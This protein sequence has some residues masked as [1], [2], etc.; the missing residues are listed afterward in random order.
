MILGLLPLALGAT[1][2]DLANSLSV[3]S[4]DI[5]SANVNGNGQAYDVL[6]N[7]GIL[8]PT[9][10]SDFAI[11]SSG[12][13]GLSP[14]PG[15]DLPPMGRPQGDSVKFTLELAVPTNA[16]SFA[17]DF[18]FLS[19]EYPEYVGSPYNDVFEAN[20]S[21][22]AWSGNAAV[23]SAGNNITVNSALFSVT[24]TTDLQGS[25]FDKGVGGGT[26]WLTAVVPADPGTTL[27]LELFVYDVS[28]G[29]Y[30]SV[31]LLDDFYWSESEIST[32]VVVTDI[33][34]SYLS[35]K[36]G[37]AN[38]GQQT[39]VFGD[40][41]NE[42]C[43]VFFDNV[44]ALSTTYV[45]ETELLAEVPAHAPDLVDVKVA[46]IGIEDSL[47]GG[48]TYY[49]EEAGEMPPLIQSVS[50]HVLD[51]LGGERVLVSGEDF[52]ERVELYLDD[53][54]LTVSWV[55]ASTLE[56]DSPEHEPGLADLRA[57]N[58]S[59]LEDLRSGA[60]VYVEAVTWP[61]EDSGTADT[62]SGDTGDASSSAA[63]KVEGCSCSAMATTP[64]LGWMAVVLP[65][66]LWWRRTS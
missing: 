61:P 7:L 49:D 56:F 43:E 37:T 29:V 1:P 55:D 64:G 11:L 60:V 8:S 26:G 13:V 41:F 23:D 53:Q 4:G 65:L 27:T 20:V 22:T 45:S 39:S 19:A 14:E 25:G 62:S 59:G 21:G 30:D 50:P 34:I 31:V 46:C 15:Q 32:P 33:D 63:G 57:V 18:Y 16:N 10:G 5:V 28:D 6:A 44:E 2:A 54:P 35:P 24:A 12:K 51:T 66:L 9:E 42:T 36:R 17:F 52:D 48:Y 3:P 58:P 40:G 38:G 47:V